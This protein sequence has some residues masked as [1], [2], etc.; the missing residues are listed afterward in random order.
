VQ[1]QIF[2][3]SPLI[4]PFIRH[5]LVRRINRALLAW[6]TRRVLARLGFR[7]PIVWIFVPHFVSLLDAIPNKGV[8]YYITDEYTATPNVESA[9]IAGLEREILE[10]A[11][12]VF[13]VSQRLVEQK[14]RLSPRVYLSRH[15]VDAVHFLRA[16]QPGTP[17]PADISGISGPVAGFFGLIT[18]YIDLDLLEYAARRLPDVSFVLI[19]HAAVSVEQTA[20]IPNVHYLGHRDYNDLPGYLKA[21][22]VCL[23]LYRLGAF[24]HHANPKKLREYIAGGKPVVSVRIGEVEHYQDLVYIA[25]DYDEYVECIRRAVRENSPEKATLR[26]EAMAKESWESRVDAISAIVARHVPVTNPSLPADR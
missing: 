20:S 13:A 16:A 11:D 19:G 14:S 24:S 23:L 8:I 3:Y 15:G 2:V 12:V 21:F 22:D 18:E 9:V 5:A 6:S 4:L 10:R 17:V 7:D 1:P 25:D 26:I